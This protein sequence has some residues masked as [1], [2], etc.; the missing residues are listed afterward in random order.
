MEQDSSSTLETCGTCGQTG[1]HL[2]GCPA[3]TAVKRAGWRRLA[4][5][6]AL[7]AA[8]ALLYVVGKLGHWHGH[9]VVVVGWVMA[10]CGLVGACIEKWAEESGRAPLLPKWVRVVTGVLLFGGFAVLATQSHG[11]GG[12]GG[13]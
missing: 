10:G 6:L 8:A 5:P 4:V 11:G 2:P 12:G 1:E 7:L 9:R 3:E 13:E